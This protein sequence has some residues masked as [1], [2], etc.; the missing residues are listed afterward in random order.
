MHSSDAASLGCFNLDSL[1]FSY[2]CKAQVTGDYK[3]AGKYKEIPVSV[4]IGDNQASV[5]SALS[6]EGDVLI[7]V[8]TGSQVSMI[9]EKIVRAE[10][11]E[12]RPF[13]EGKYLLVGAALCGG[14]AYAILKD[15]YKKILGYNTGADSDEVYSIMAKMLESKKSSEGLSVDTRFSGTR[16]NKDIRG[17]VSGIS[18]EN[19]TPENLTY[20]TLS[21]MIGELYSMY[22][23][24]G[25]VASGIVG[26]GNGI[27]KNE[28]L[29]RVA[30]DA[31]GADMKIPTHT[32]EAA[33]GAAMFALIS[34]GVY[35]NMASAAK[36]IRY[37]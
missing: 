5:L 22:S 10:G 34:A 2:D 26:S 17:S 27:R 15:F 28:A 6:G 14:R 32:E 8:G 20:G 19:F 9:S 12:V 13:F 4:A 16:A 23:S 36:M 31:F 18:E 24:M 33:Y 21:G 3:I 35:E 7:N 37:N 25:K 30:E 11:V 29:I 1:S